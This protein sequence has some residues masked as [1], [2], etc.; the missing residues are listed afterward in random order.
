[1]EYKWDGDIAGG[2]N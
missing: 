1:M 2:G